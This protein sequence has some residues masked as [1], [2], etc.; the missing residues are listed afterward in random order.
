MLGRHEDSP[1]ASQA[2]CAADALSYVIAVQTMS[3]RCGTDEAALQSCICSSSPVFSEVESRVLTDVT[4]S[5]GTSALED[6]SSVDVVMSQYCN[7]KSTYTF[8]TPTENIVQAY[9]TEVSE[10]E[11]LPPCARSALSEA[12]MGVRKPKIQ[13]LIRI[14]G[15]Y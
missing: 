13:P 1:T 2:P 5:C 12:V 4:S 8:P 9:I 7:P 14:Q 10:M 15:G 6:R 11:Y 3:T